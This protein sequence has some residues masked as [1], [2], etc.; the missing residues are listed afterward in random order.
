MVQPGE[1]GSE[2][3]DVVDQGFQGLVVLNTVLLPGPDDYG[4]GPNQGHPEALLIGLLLHVIDELKEQ[5]WSRNRGH[6][7]IKILGPVV[8]VL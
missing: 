4:P 3:D 1:L 5:S 8:R 7:L 2:V 6:S